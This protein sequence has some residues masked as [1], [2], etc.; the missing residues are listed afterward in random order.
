MASGTRAMIS[1]YNELVKTAAIYKTILDIH[2]D[3]HES[4][5]YNTK[6]LTKNYRELI[7]KD[8]MLR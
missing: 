8:D 6:N 4:S 3:L 7:E 1:I 5:L 2:P